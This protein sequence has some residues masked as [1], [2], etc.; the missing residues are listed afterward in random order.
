[1]FKEIKIK[2]EETKIS[3]ISECLILL[4]YKLLGG[5]TYE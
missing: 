4:K 3:T 2:I 5:G 1:M